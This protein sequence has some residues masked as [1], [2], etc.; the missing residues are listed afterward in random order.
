[1]NIP[2]IVW[3]TETGE[4]IKFKDM[5]YPQMEG[6]LNELK[7]NLTH[8]FGFEELSH[9]VALNT[10]ISALEEYYEKR[11]EPKTILTLSYV[12]LQYIGLDVRSEEHTYK[13]QSRSHIVI[14]L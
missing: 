5:P 13:L 7:E 1:M 6:V 4:K 11:Y 8:G 2:E 14:R 9:Y 12:D 10:F 3:T